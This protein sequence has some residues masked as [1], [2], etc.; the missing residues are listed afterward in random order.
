[1]DHMDRTP[2]K[3]LV[4]SVTAINTAVTLSREEGSSD[5]LLKYFKPC[6]ADEYM[7]QTE[8]EW[9]KMEGYWHD[10]KSLIEEQTKRRTTWKREGNKECQQRYHNKNKL[11]G[12][13]ILSS[14][15][16]PGGTQQKRKLS[17][18]ITLIIF[19]KN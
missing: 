3:K 9:V 6:D 17:N 7:A 1:M 15:R 4:K 11:M 13:E 2:L 16:S 19:R 18:S 8:R 10:Q 5:G 12:A 14:E